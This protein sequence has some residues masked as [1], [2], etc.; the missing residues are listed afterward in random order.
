MSLVPPWL[1]GYHRAWLRRDLIAGLVVWSVVAPQVVAYAQIAGLPP[2]AGLAAAPGALLGYALLG[3]SRTLIVSATTATS[4]LSAA[5]VGPLAG[6]DVVRFA[7]LSAALALVAAGVLVAAGALRAGA[8]IDFISKP[9]TTGFLFGLGLTVAAGQLPKIAGVDPGDGNFFPM[10]ADLLGKLAEAHAATVAVG[11]G[12]VAALLALRRLAPR[13]PGSLIVLAAAIALSELL[14]LRAHGVSV[15]GELPDALPDPALPDVSWGDVASL[16]PA[17]F[18]VVVLT[19]EAAGV[20]RALATKDG[21]EVDVNRELVAIGGANLLAG[22]SS[23]FVQSGGASQ[24]AAASS[25]GARTQLVSI[26]AAALVLL[27]GA[28]LAPLFGPLPDATLA[29]IVVVAISGFFRVDELRR[30]ARIRSSALV[31]ALIALGGVLLLGVLPGLLVAAVLSLGLVVQRIS[32]PWVGRL[33][34][35]PAS[36][37]W[38]RTDLHDAWSVSPEIVVA[39]VDGPLFYA[40]AG[41][42]K[43]RLVAL[44]GGLEPRPAVAVLSLDQSDLDLE[45]LDM[46]DELAD[47]LAGLGVELRLAGVRT[48]PRE[49]LRRTGLADR[50]RLEPTLDAA[51]RD[52]GPPPAPRSSA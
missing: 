11:L 51:T 14:D 13:L 32:R 7:A 39:R 1:R 47:T 30:F 49:L 2:E 26:V 35:D 8:I 50:V 42:V 33:G 46:L 23:G 15:V 22:L 36:G 9:V 20:A 19:T 43:D 28:V 29:A 16:V 17:A 25:A 37:T 44:A 41:T 10:V 45:T 27:T 3:T 52:G 31:L 24:T 4:A 12:S 48:R 21:Y 40:N 18:G 6:G 34:R 38:G 5:V